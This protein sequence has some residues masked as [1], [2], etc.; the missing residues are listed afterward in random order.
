MRLTE[1]LGFLSS[2]ALYI[3]REIAFTIIDHD[4]MMQVH[5]PTI[6]QAVLISLFSLHRLQTPA[7]LLSSIFTS[8]RTFPP[9]YRKTFRI[10]R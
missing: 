7:A 6:T 5:P 2:Q 10:S 1:I 4:Q 9:Q 8:I 3:A